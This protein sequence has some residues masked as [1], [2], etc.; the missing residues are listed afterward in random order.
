MRDLDTSVAAGIAVF[1]AW[2]PRMVGALAVLLVGYFVGRAVEGSG[3][4]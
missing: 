1:F 4:V 3:R 2:L